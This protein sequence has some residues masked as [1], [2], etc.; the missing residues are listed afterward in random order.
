MAENDHSLPPYH[1][2]FNNPVNAIDPDGNWAIVIPIIK[3]L[4][5]VGSAAATYVGIR[6]VDQEIKNKQ[7]QGTSRSS[8]I[9][10]ALNKPTPTKA[11]IANMKGRL[12]AEGNQDV[13]KVGKIPDLNGKSLDEVDETLKDAGFKGGESTKAGSQ[14]DKQGNESKGGYRTYRNPDGS[15]VTVKPD[16]SVVRETKPQYDPNTGQRTNRGEKLIK[17]ENGFEPSRD[18]KKIH[19]NRDKYPE[20]VKL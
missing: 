3:A 10:S 5:A 18:Q 7:T 1:Y 19:E 4:I 13:G 17:T 15:T 2:A 14:V 9:P 11:D 8:Y 16:G 6:A 12:N 20:R